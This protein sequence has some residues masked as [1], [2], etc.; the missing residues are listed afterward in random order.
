MATSHFD[1]GEVSADVG[2]PC[3]CLYCFDGFVHGF[4]IVLMVLS[5]FIHCFCHV[6][7]VQSPLLI[8]YEPL[9][10]W[11][12]G[13]TI[14]ATLNNDSTRGCEHYAT[15]CMTSPRSAVLSGKTAMGRL[16]TGWLGKF[17]S[18]HLQE[19]HLFAGTVTI[20]LFNIAM[21]NPS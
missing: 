8:Y 14:W 3:F 20:W 13:Y 1:L 5:C 6:S 11:I 12:V 21:E 16:R 2:F 4:F 19:T 10:E 7:S 9:L 15:S 18:E 17:R